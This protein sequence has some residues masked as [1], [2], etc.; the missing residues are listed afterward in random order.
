MNTK[1]KPQ[2]QVMTGNAAAAIGAT[3]ARPD[4]VA[5]YPITPQTEIIEQLSKFHAS[6]ELDAEMITVEGENSAM[7]AV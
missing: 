6:G 1:E 5:A 7:N 3:L 2:L 4:V